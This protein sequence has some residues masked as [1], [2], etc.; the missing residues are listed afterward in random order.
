MFLNKN[1]D[2]YKDTKP[3]PI[4]KANI[5]LFDTISPTKEF[6]ILKT[7]DRVQSFYVEDNYKIPSFSY[8]RD[9]SLL[10][11]FGFPDI[12]LSLNDEY[13]YKYPHLNKKETILANLQTE[14]GTPNGFNQQMRSMADGEKVEDIKTA[15]AEYEKGLNELNRML[16]N[17]MQKEATTK[18]EEAAKDL[19]VD[20]LKTE[21][22][23]AEGNKKA[24]V[25]FKPAKISKAIER[26]EK[27]KE[28]AE[29]KENRRTLMTKVARNIRKH[30][31]NKT[32]GVEEKKEEEGKEEEKKNSQEQ[33]SEENQK[34]IKTKKQKSEKTPLEIEVENKRREDL[35]EQIKNLDSAYYAKTTSVNKINANINHLV[36][37]L[38]KLPQQIEKRKELQHQI[39]KLDPD[40]YDK[41]TSLNS[42][43]AGIKN[44]EKVLE[45]LSQGKI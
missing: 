21:I 35:Q 22:K 37:V 1:L 2:I 39:Q 31:Y 41:N 29:K 25:Q 44:L 19:E 3:F 28:I 43:N 7:N 4:S 6:P 10:D 15:D 45:K 8:K 32:Q 9:D 36:H 18:A 23:T 17:E 11:F 24:R 5:P 20:R 30:N 14:N 38:K 34:N 42:P 13:K 40:I 12:Q 16:E 27:E 26:E 33:S